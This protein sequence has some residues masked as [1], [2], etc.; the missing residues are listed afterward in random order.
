MQA[1][2]FH[3]CVFILGLVTHAEQAGLLALS[4][5]STCFPGRGPQGPV[6]WRALVILGHA[7][8]LWVR[9]KKLAGR[10]VV[11]STGFKSPKLKVPK[12]DLDALLA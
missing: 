8:H 2:L 11:R 1:D 12:T 7:S 3:D 4:D 10:I 6:L 5:V 9:R